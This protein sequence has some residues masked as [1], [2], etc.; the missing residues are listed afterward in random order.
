MLRYLNETKAA[1][2]MERA[3]ADVIAEGKDVTYDLRKDRNAPS[4]G[5]SQVAGAI[6]EKLSK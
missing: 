2:K 6:I 5:T 3:I 4:A 1:D